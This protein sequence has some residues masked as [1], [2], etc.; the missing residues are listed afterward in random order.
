MD[1]DK[2][3]ATID[4]PEIRHC[5]CGERASFGFGPPSGASV[6]AD[7]W[8][9]AAH[10]EEG[11]RRWPRRYGPPVTNLSLFLTRFRREAR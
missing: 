1:D 5:M 2:P 3:I 7:V 10:R 11:Q 9:C 8:Y 6:D 4:P